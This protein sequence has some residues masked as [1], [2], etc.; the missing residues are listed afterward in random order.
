VIEPMRAICRSMVA[1]FLCGSLAITTGLGLGFPEP[2]GPQLSMQENRYDF[3]DAFRGELLRRSFMVRNTGNATLELSNVVPAPT[4][5]TAVS[6]N[7]HSAISY[8]RS[9]LLRPV[10]LSLASN[11]VRGSAALNVDQIPAQTP[12]PQKSASRPADD[13]GCHASLEFNFPAEVKPGRTGVVHTALV[14]AN[15]SGKVARDYVLY[16]NDPAH[17]LITFILTANIKPLPDWL[18]RIQNRDVLQG[19]ST[20]GYQVWPT[21]HPIVRLAKG[22][23]LKVSLRLT[24]D[25]ENK[26]NAGVAADPAQALRASGGIRGAPSS[27]GNG[28]GD[29]A[30]VKSPKVTAP[31]RLADD[32][33]TF[34]VRPDPSGIVSWLDI[35]ISPIL[36]TGTFSCSRIAPVD[37]GSRAELPIEVTLS[38]IDDDFVIAPALIKIDELAI[39]KDQAAIEIGR[40]EIRRMLRRF[41]VKSV[42]SSLPFVKFEV[43]ALVPAKRYAVKVRLIGEPALTPGP[44]KGSIKVLTD[45]KSNPMIEVPL[46]LGLVRDGGI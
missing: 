12:G 9:G 39:P 4:K 35:D 23:G 10:A 20:G 16:T 27:G 3:G 15:E 11:P 34:H 18:E 40:F 32:K 1:I 28:G 5:G 22:E 8:L 19:E 30:G 45:D 43:Q 33:L 6:S 21:A 13:C 24:S 17:P 38:V 46:S 7:E 36:E 37:T 14:T 44:Y 29:G 42:S 2:S 41:R 26:E 31:T 25:K